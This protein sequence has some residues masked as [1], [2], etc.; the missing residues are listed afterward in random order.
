MNLPVGSAVAEE[1]ALKDFDIQGITD[2]LFDKLFSGY[3]VVTID[4]YD[5]ME[6]GVMIFRKGTLAGALYE[7]MNYDI[8]VFGEPA[9]V[10]VFNAL[11]AEHG[12]VDIY[13]LSNQQ[14][15]LVTAF[16][17]KIILPKPLGKKDI[18]RMYVKE[19][20][21]QYAKQ[22]L[23]EVLKTHESRESVFKR[24]GLSRLG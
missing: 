21:D 24:L 5:G 8:L 11:A 17:D 3:I 16:N 19:F 13:N 6:E 23:A 10:Q 14:I 9:L 1:V 18:K 4:G 22:V 12:A 7:Y 15:D 2:S 20:A